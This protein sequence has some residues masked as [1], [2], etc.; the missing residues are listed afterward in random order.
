MPRNDGMNTPEGDA[1]CPVRC[2]KAGDSVP[3]VGSRANRAQRVCVR[4]G[5]S[6][7]RR[8]VS[9]GLT[10]TPSGLRKYGFPSSPSAA[11]VVVGPKKIG[12]A[13][14]KT[15]RWAVAAGA[16]CR[17]SPHRCRLCSRLSLL[18]PRCHTTREQGSG[19]GHGVGVEARAADGG[20][21]GVHA[22]AAAQRGGRRQAEWGARRGESA[23]GGSVCGLPA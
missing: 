21:R 15:R 1:L 10:E 3:R 23:A 14:V 8:G 20:A 5:P 11:R 13:S 6:S 18:H 22:A 17:L 4:A 19:S 16:K 2:A 7:V 9:D 12:R